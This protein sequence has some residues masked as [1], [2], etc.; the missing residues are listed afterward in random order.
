MI[1][2][3]NTID[4]TVFWLLIRYQDILVPMYITDFIGESLCFHSCVH[5]WRNII[6][7]LHEN[8]S[9]YLIHPIRD[10]SIEVYPELSHWIIFNFNDCEGLYLLTI[11]SYCA[12]AHCR[13]VWSNSSGLDI[14]LSLQNHPWPMTKDMELLT[15]WNLSAW[16]FIHHHDN[17][18]STFKRSAGNSDPIISCN[19]P[20]CF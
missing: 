1:C 15:Y 10:L 19:Y 6:T 17:C 12:S 20:P 4:E 7:V 14:V 18:T 2:T 11:S 13:S 3:I 5:L 16:Y 9:F 8:D